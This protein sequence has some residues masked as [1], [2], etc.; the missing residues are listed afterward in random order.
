MSPIQGTLLSHGLALPLVYSPTYKVTAF[1]THSE[2]LI[3]QRYSIEFE[4]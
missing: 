1:P 4:S 2:K 3:L